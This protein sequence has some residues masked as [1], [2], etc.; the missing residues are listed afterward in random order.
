MTEL[1]LVPEKANHAGISYPATGVLDG[2][3]RCMRRVSRA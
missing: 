3:A 2:G 1:S